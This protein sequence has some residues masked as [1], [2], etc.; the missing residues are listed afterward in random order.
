M[1][2]KE[3]YIF[4]LFSDGYINEKLCHSNFDRL[5]KLVIPALQYEGTTHI[6]Q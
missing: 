3:F 1:S 2:R 6:A 5:Q 4:L